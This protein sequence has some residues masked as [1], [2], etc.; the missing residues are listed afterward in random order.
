MACRPRHRPIRFAPDIKPATATPNSIPPLR[1]S[2]VATATPD[3]GLSHH[4]FGLPPP[5]SPSSRSRPTVELRHLPNPDATSRPPQTLRARAA[6]ALVALRPSSPRAVF[7]DS[8]TAA[9]PSSIAASLSVVLH[10]LR[11]RHLP[12]LRCRLPVT[13]PSPR[14]VSLTSV[15]DVAAAVANEVPRRPSPVVGESL[16]RISTT[17]IRNTFGFAHLT[18]Q[19]RR[20]TPTPPPRS[21]YLGSGQSET[22]MPMRRPQPIDQLSFRARWCLYCTRADSGKNNSKVVIN[23]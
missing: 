18:P 11:H 6:I 7:L 16:Q 12:E 19:R 17:P 23:G 13:A 8:N 10:L 15:T 2:I 3:S 14:G 9:S 5:P 21:T 4:W 22:P 1:A 20:R